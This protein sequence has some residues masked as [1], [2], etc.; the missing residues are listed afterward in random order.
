M[1]D[2]LTCCV[3]FCRRTCRN[4]KGF[5][6][7]ICPDHWRLVSRRTKRR[8]RLAVMAAKRADERF[9]EVYRQQNGFTLQQFERAWAAKELAQGLWTRCKREAIE[10]AA[11]LR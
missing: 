9:Q 6:E 2:R 1:V 11:G 3:P 7:W 5:S 4:E 8:R 10:G